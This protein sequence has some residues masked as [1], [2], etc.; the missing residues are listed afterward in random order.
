MSQNSSHDPQSGAVDSSTS[1][2]PQYGQPQ[3]GQPQW[4][5]PGLTQ[6]DPAQPHL[7]QPYDVKQPEYAAQPEYAGSPQWPAYQPAPN[8]M[9]YGQPAAS[10]PNVLGIVAVVLAVII[11]PIGLI[12]GIVSWATARKS[13]RSRTLGIVATCVGAVICI[14]VIVASIA[15]FMTVGRDAISAVEQCQQQGNTGTV[16][17][18]GQEMQCTQVNSELENN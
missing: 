13:G 12:L 8:Q 15:F 5:Q 6:P 1:Q 14:G 18:M 7:T 17:F 2:T 10:G 11:A 9:A 4:G 16:V 3:Y